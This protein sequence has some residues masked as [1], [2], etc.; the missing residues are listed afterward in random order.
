MRKSLKKNS[1]APFYMF[2][3]INVYQMASLLFFCLK[4]TQK[5]SPATS[6][7]VLFNM[8]HRR[9]NA[10]EAISTVAVLSLLP[11]LSQCFTQT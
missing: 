1:D 6:R 11:N 10:Y 2:K 3:F 5:E 9:K 7:F 8:E 4:S